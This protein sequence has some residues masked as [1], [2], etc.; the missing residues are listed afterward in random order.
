MGT[1]MLLDL[2][3]A[4]IEGRQRLQETLHLTNRIL[5]QVI[6]V[7]AVDRFYMDTLLFHVHIVVLFESSSHER[8]EYLISPLIKQL[9]LIQFFPCH[10]IHDI[11]MLQWTQEIKK[12]FLGIRMVYTNVY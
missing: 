5:F 4:K 2:D 12:R 11:Q 10:H 6:S 1:M 9:P 3:D 8:N 7:M